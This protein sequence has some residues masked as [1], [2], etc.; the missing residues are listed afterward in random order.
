VLHVLQGGH[1]RVECSP[2]RI[3]TPTQLAHM[4]ASHACLESPKHTGTHHELQS[5]LPTLPAHMLACMLGCDDA[6]ARALPQWRRCA[7]HKHGARVEIVISWVVCCW[8]PVYL[9]ACLLAYLHGSACACMHACMPAC[10]HAADI[11]AR[12]WWL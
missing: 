1:V 6:N 10:Q 11:R 9:L 2:V 8:L 12:A 5:W 7:K 3:S 4:H